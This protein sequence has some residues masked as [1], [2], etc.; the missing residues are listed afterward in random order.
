MCGAI[1]RGFQSCC[2]AFSMSLLPWS[3]GVF[4]VGIIAQLKMRP[5]TM[6]PSW[7]RLVLWGIGVFAW[8]GGGVISLGHAME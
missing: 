2:L 6:L 5:F 4:T 7:L 3:A 1:M 8:I